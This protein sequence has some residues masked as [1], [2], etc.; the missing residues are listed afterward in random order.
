M[1]EDSEIEMPSFSDCSG[2]R[3]T[4]KTGEIL[5]TLL[6]LC[7]F[8]C[9]T[10]GGRRQKGRQLPFPGSSVH[11]KQR[12]VLG[13]LWDWIAVWRQTIRPPPISGH[14]DLLRG[15]TCFKQDIDKMVPTWIRGRGI[16]RHYLWS[17][18]LSPCPEVQVCI[19]GW[20]IPWYASL[21]VCYLIFPHPRLW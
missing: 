10:S 6:C 3:S 4:W 7:F 9:D 11:L 17:R 13:Y 2:T 15:K 1:L 18:E 14:L 12:W 21:A 16:V 20:F 5:V 8:I 19:S